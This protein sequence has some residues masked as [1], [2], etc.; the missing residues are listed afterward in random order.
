MERNLRAPDSISQFQRSILP[1]ILIPDSTSP[2][3]PTC[4]DYRIAFREILT[5]FIIGTA[6]RCWVRPFVVLN[7]CI[8]PCLQRSV[9]LFSTLPNYFLGWRLMGLISN[10]NLSNVS[11]HPSGVMYIIFFLLACVFV[12]FISVIQIQIPPIATLGY[13]FLALGLTMEIHAILSGFQTLQNF[14]LFFFRKIFFSIFNFP[15]MVDS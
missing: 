13:Y 6:F 12:Y 7:T 1:S 11:S 10:F 9:Y 3:I 14:G 8:A 2:P 15:C 4:C 5:P